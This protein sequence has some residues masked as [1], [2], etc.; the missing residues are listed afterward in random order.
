MNLVVLISGGGSNL[1]AIIDQVQLG[2][3]PVSLKGVISNVANVKGLSRAREAN[4][5]TAVVSHKDYTDRLSF[6][7]ALMQ[8]IDQFEPD[9]I[10]LAGF[11]RI[12]TSEF[13]SHY[14][15]RLIN[16][17]PS[18]LPAY[19]GTNTH[20]RVLDNR[21][22]WHGASVHF[23]VPEVDAGP[24]ILQGRLRVGQ[25][26]EADELAARVLKIE[27]KIYP[28]AVRW[29]AQGRLQIDDSAVLL[30]GETSADQLQTFDV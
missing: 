10:V 9:L 15:G 11:M 28:L 25:T 27:H 16:I 19:P 29:F 23:V 4:I 20:Q 18:L 13:V 24:I 7:R 26:T 22:T 5:E 8:V 12:L 14:S 30:D 1:Q 17:H 2:N 6:D 21:E 3:I